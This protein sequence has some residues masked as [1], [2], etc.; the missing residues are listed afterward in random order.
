[1][2]RS[3]TMATK[4]IL[5]FGVVLILLSIVGVFAFITINNA[6]TDFARYRHI[7]HSSNALSEVEANQLRAWIKVKD[8]LV[9]NGQEEDIQGFRQID[10]AAKDSLASVIAETKNAEQ[11]RLLHTAQEDID[12]Y[13]KGFD[14][15]VGLIRERN[16]LV[17]VEMPDTGREI[18]QALTEIWDQANRREDLEASAQSAKALRHL[19]LARIHVRYFVDNNAP[20]HV[21]RVRQEWHDLRETLPQLERELTDPE[22]RRRLESVLQRQN[23]YL[24]QFE[25]LV[26]TIFER[27]EIVTNTLDVLG[28]K[29]SSLLQQVRHQY[30]AEQNE[31][32]PRVQAANEQAVIIITVLSLLAVLLGVVIAWMIIRNVMAQLGRDPG[33]IADITKQV[34]AGNLVIDFD[35]TNLR[36]VYK[37]MYDMVDRLR[38]IVSEVRAGADNLSSASSEVSSTAQSLSQ[39]AT[40]QAA[41]VEE[42]SSSIEQLNASVQQNTENARV[43]NRIAKSS[44][45]EARRGGEAVARTVAAMKEIASKIGLIEDIAYKTNLLA[46]NAAIEAARAGE[47][48]KGFTVVAAE[49]RKLAENS[50][51]TAQE[52]NQLATSS[53]AIAEEAGRLLE[54][55]VPNIIKT[56]DL[57][58]EI[59]AA[60]GEQASGVA[61]INEAMNQLDKATQQNAS[62]SEELA[63]TA[64]ELS[65]Q[66]SQLQ[67]TMS[68]FRIGS[69]GSRAKGRSRTPAPAASLLR[70]DDGAIDLDD[71]DRK[72]FERF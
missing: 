40:E 35:Q 68:F 38:Q 6:S 34:A 60:S 1:M 70:A 11:L 26:K 13:S 12:G 9:R 39:A 71:L 37:D 8:V 2:F 62:A 61:Q 57:V 53:V 32:G 3:M 51:M 47:H 45:E 72:D 50:G 58:E 46:L 15:I 14:R 33:V 49:V 27:N 18:E 41:S 21:D 36:G 42:I 44:A 64:E 7:A 24:N 48:G 10:K 29:A 28:P 63:A 31:L 30:F 52:I 59:T 23:D 19:L 20:S 54:Q 56:A 66:A 22:Q 16:R 69:G 4:L 43:T 65:G 67:E 25:L 5:G 17:D 55:M